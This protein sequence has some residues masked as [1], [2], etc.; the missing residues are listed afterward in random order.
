MMRLEKR[1]YLLLGLE[2][3]GGRKLSGEEAK[4]LVYE[5]VFS[6]LGESGAAK[7]S[8]QAKEFDTDRQLLVVKCAASELDGVIAALAAK[9]EFKGGPVALRLKKISGS[10]GKLVG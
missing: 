2:A 10:I 8:V 1:R 3:E 9:T 5:G 6:L 7:A 4:H